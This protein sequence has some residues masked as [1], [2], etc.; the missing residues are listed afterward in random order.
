MSNA[1][2]GSETLQK[3]Q[4]STSFHKSKMLLNQI[5]ATT[6]HTLECVEGQGRDP[7]CCRQC[8]S[9]VL[10]LKFSSYKKIFSTAFVSL[11]GD[12]SGVSLAS[13]SETTLNYPL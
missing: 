2:N 13:S 7:G 9:S 11:S 10:G 3:D 5:N 8:G 6:L 4:K 12:N 1:G